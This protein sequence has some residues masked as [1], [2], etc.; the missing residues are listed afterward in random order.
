MQYNFNP[1]SQSRFLLKL[2]RDKHGFTQDELAMLLDISRSQLSMAESRS[3]TLPREA[4]QKFLK[5]QE[6]LSA[7]SGPATERQWELQ[8]QKKRQAFTWRCEQQLIEMQ[9]KI[10]LLQGE[11]PELARQEQAQ[12]AVIRE[13]DTLPDSEKAMALPTMNIEIIYRRCFSRLA[14]CD[15]SVRL[16]KL[17]QIKILAAQAD[18]VRQ[19]IA[20]EYPA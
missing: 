1:A 6:S 16:D 8:E 7:G 17:L 19:F 13:W 10:S 12:L 5:L 15:L 14:K 20:G 11:I 18:V 2:F 4:G 3:G 9:Y